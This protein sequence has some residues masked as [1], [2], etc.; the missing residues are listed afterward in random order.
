MQTQVDRLRA[1][2]EET[3][4]SVSVPGAGTARASAH[5][6]GDG[7]VTLGPPADGGRTFDARRVDEGYALLRSLGEMLSRT[8]SRRVVENFERIELCYLS[9]ERDIEELEGEL[10]DT[11]SKRL[12]T[13]ATGRAGQRSG[14]HGRA[15]PSPLSERFGL[16]A[17]Q[18]RSFEQDGCLGPL[19]LCSEDEMG[20]IR[21]WIDRSGFMHRASP[22]YGAASPRGS[23]EQRDWHLVLPEIHELCTHPG[24]VAVMEALLGPDLLL[25]RSQFMRKESGG[26]ALGWHQDGSFPGQSVVPSVSP[27]KTVSAWI[28]IDEARVENGCVWVVPGTHNETLDYVRRDVDRGQGLFNRGFEIEYAVS[29]ARATPM[30]LKPGQFMVFDCQTLHG[31]SHNPSPWRRLGLA[32]RYTSA[33]VKVYENQK[34]DGQGYPLDRFGCLLVRGEDRYGHNVMVSPPRR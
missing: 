2:L 32:V 8:A 24:L 12:A 4:L 21:R 11:R 7:R 15:A 26:A 22:I 1:D 3:S 6:P 29:S 9:L 25:W 14:D 16:T 18:V 5:H 30:V 17:A 13:P 27:M 33:D 31:S 23:A 10:R 34:V 20:R 28:A 19:T